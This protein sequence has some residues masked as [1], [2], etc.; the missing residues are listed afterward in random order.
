MVS[1]IAMISTTLIK[2][3][4]SF[5]A[6]LETQTVI[7]TLIL[8]FVA[9]LVIT[10][11]VMLLVESF[12]VGDPGK[13]TVY[14]LDAWERA[15]TTP[16]IKKAIYNTISLAVTRSLIATVIGIFIA[17]L[18]ARTDIPWKGWFEFMFWISYFLPALPV[19]LGWILLLDSKF[20][21]INQWLVML[22]FIENPPFNIHS[23]WGIVWV[24]L[25]AT[26]I[27]IR[28]MLLTPAFR[29]LDASLEESSRVA[30]AGPLKTL[31]RI[32][33]PIMMPPILIATVL[34]LIRSLE[35][36]EIELILGVPI[37]LEV[38]STKIYSWIVDE[39]G[40]FAAA[41]ALGAFFL[42]ILMVLVGMQQLY[43]RR[44]VFTTV[45][46]R[47]F[48]ARPIP[49]GRW[50]WPAFALILLIV[51]TVT[52][53]PTGFVFLGTF[54]KLFGYFNIPEPW[55]LD[56]WTHVLSDPILMSSLKNT[57]VLGFW[58]AIISVLFCCVIAYIVV[59]T[60]FFGRELLDF[61][62][63]LPYSIPGI[64]LGLAMIWSLLLVNNFIPIYG[65]MAALVIAMSIS[66][67]PLGVQV[68]KSFL[69]QLGDELE[70]S[71]RVSGASWLY[72]FRR[73]LFPILSPCL[74]VVGLLTFISA[75][76]DIGTVV[77]LAT[78]ETRTLALLMLDYTAGAE[79]ERATVVACMIVILV[80]V[81]AVI[82][83]VLGGQ[84]H[85]RD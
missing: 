46:G 53:I 30:G 47:G 38:F 10:P 73:I 75:A 13:P 3:A 14:G 68:I 74:I 82:A 40:D 12:D 29:N 58:S 59:K 27:G 54:M 45:T 15:A 39:P 77:L 26:T 83:R 78:G 28:V 21:L 23:Y 55:T 6:R 72:T 67:L 64:L 44:K 37:G 5:T 16:G 34:G 80:I 7:F 18:L 1:T 71:S 25:T 69:L 63:W 51:L 61:L 62:S 36:F 9:F 8:C 31:R 56:N 70:E 17:W 19:A 49:L 42:V 79:L 35:A 33:I 32:I 57:L 11:L 48:S 50:K 43:L 22:P 2:T 24:H 4:R 85:I 41:G 76:R 84:F 65:T 60:R 66:R 20:G 52:V 81:G